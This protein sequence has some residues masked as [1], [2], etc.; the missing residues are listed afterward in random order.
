MARTSIELAASQDEAWTTLQLLPTWEGVAGIEDLKEAR[1][2][3]AGNLVGFRF[4]IDTAVGRVDGRA[5]VVPRP[6]AMTVEAD[7]KGLEIV[8]KVVVTSGGHTA[9]TALVD[10]TAHATSFLSRPLAVTLNAML[11]SAIDDEAE[12]IASR[13]GR[14]AEG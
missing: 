1:Y 3:G 9:S 2:D 8:I 12:K 4:A 13:I 10:A 5:K 7:Q 14:R 6:P 11:D